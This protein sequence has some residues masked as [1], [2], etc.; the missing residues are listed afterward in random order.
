MRSIDTFTRVYD[1]GLY[2]LNIIQNIFSPTW[3]EMT[4][5]RR[6]GNTVAGKRPAALLPAGHVLRS[7]VKG[8]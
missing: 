3:K 2:P 6:Q 7:G 1:K 4:L 5:E 8:N